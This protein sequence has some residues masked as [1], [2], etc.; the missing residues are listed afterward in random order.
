[1]LCFCSDYILY[2]GYYEVYLIFHFSVLHLLLEF[3]VSEPSGGEKE[4]LR[5]PGSLMDVWPTLKY[6]REKNT[7]QRR[8][9]IMKVS[10]V[11]R[12]LSVLLALVF[13]F[14][15]LPANALATEIGEAEKTTAL[16]VLEI[17]AVS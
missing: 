11:R 8:E 7:K 9:L 14:E 12:F 4:R 17:S 10:W 16:E 3:F 1:M 5:F 13:I 2:F 6:D 15:L